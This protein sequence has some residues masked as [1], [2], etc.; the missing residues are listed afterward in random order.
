[1]ANPTLKGSESASAKK[2]DSYIVLAGPK[3]VLRGPLLVV[4]VVALVVLP[5]VALFISAVSNSSERQQKEFD[6][7]QVA[8]ALQKVSDLP[9]TI[10]E[11][12]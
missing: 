12:I 7:K 9:N 4:V 2:T 8:P 5:A 6:Y 3:I 10:R 11:S 1:M